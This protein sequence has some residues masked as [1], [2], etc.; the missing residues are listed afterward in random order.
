MAEIVNL[1]RYRKAKTKVA[2]EVEAANNRLIF[3]RKRS[4]K[5]TAGKAA[6]KAKFDLDGK[7]LED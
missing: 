1:N 3:G 6:A 5:D 2:A 4:E 7:K